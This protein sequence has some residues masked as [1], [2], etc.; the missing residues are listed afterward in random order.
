VEGLPLKVFVSHTSELRQYPQERSFVV[1]AERAI[2]RAGCVPLDMEYFTAR[3]DKPADY[4]DQEIGKAD[5]YVGVLGFRYGSPVSGE[6]EHSY[7]ELEFDAATAAGLDRLVYLLD[8]GA[9]GQL[10]EAC[11]AD[12]VYAERQAAFRTRVTQAGIT[13]AW[14]TSPDQLEMLVFQSLTNLREKRSA[15]VAVSLGSRPVDMQ[16]RDDLLAEMDARLAGAP[17]PGIVALYGLGGAGKTSVAVEYAFRQRDRLGVAWRLAAEDPATLDTGF[18]ELAVRLGAGTGNPVAAVHAALARR[19]DW[20]LLFDNVPDPAAIS[21]HIPPA[22]R[23]QVVITSRY[24][25]WP[26]QQGL[27]VPV[28]GQDAAARFLL[29]RVGPDG[30]AEQ[31]QAALELADELGGLPL[32]LE[33]AAAYMRIADRGIASYL[34]L[35]RRRRAELLGQG[36][37]DGYDKE[38][39]TTWSLAFAALGRDTPATRLLRLAACCAPEDI[40]LDLL[41]HPRPWLDMPTAARLGSLLDHELARDE[42]VAGLRRYSLVTA[43]AGRVSVH[44]L[45]QAI[46]LDRLPEDDRTGWRRAAAAVI[47]AA[48]PDDPQDPESWPAFAA[49]LPH[50]QAT[51]DPADSDMHRIANYL[52][53]AGNYPAAVTLMRTHLRAREERGDDKADTLTARADLAQWTGSAGDGIAARDQYAALLPIR[54]RVR[55]PEDPGTLAVRA[56]LA[57]WTGETGNAAAARDQ[58]AD[59]LPVR[60][61]ILGAEH[62]DTLR[63]RAGL[64]RWTGWAGDKAA[65]RDQF[66]I[67]LPVYIRVFEAEDPELLSVRAALAYWTG[68]AGDPAAARDQYTDLLPVRERVLG[69]EHPD[70]LDT[71]TNLAFWTG[72]AGDAVA[73]RDQY[74]ALVPLYEQILGAQHPKTLAARTVLA[75]FTRQAEEAARKPKRPRRMGWPRR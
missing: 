22:G 47:K 73:A 21:G 17:E 36:T 45:V 59:L 55:G 44:R 69:A 70:T 53:L 37:P 58:F 5:V 35:F 34:D 66:A 6:P 23:G 75:Q 29:T 19:N 64:A 24:G 57:R 27:E 26:D 33:Q 67:L 46:T 16:G 74:T 3:E 51:L 14:V 54:E 25:D 65:A 1:A 72:Q 15:P 63:T 41:L 31:E 2:I 32:A 39:A 20:L 50:A 49:L 30:T 4:C 56:N 68:E 42:A 48:L 7:T 10:P 40:P 61:R 38:V 12:P 18:G 11:R 71:R 43:R 62:A 13:V 8:E 60:E 9:A 28:L 52:G